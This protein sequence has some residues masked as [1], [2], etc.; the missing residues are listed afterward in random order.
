MLI[1]EYR[2]PLP[3][4]I[5]EYE[6]ALVYMVAKASL[7]ENISGVPMV[8]I[9]SKPFSNHMG[10]GSFTHREL[11]LTNRLPEWG[12][13]VLLRSG[14]QLKIIEK[15]WNAFPYIQTIYTCPLFSEDKFEIVVESRHA[16]DTGNVSNIHNLPP[17][18]LLK[19]TVD[20][21][22]IVCDE[23]EARYYKKEEDPLLFKSKKT[24]RGPFKRGWQETTKP[25][26]CC[27]KL[28]TVNFNY[29]GLRTKVEKML[30]DVIRTIYLSIHKQIFCWIDEWYDMSDEK[31][32]EFEIKMNQSLVAPESIPP[33]MP[34]SNDE[35]SQTNKA[36]PSTMKRWLRSK[37]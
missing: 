20:H 22:D 31:V 10:K 1:K 23:L 27:Y 35:Q 13:K 28:V 3:L 19:R 11:L 33:A 25:M 18:K 34:T 30:Q 15:S 4:S 16:V 26:M 12:R 21:V 9:E 37:L 17:S 2:I 14:T 7:E 8:V 24:G 5:E 6:K 36:P 29:F 32:K